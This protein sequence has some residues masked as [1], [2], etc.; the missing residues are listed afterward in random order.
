MIAQLEIYW[1]NLFTYAFWVT[2]AIVC[3]VLW[4]YSDKLYFWFFEEVNKD[5]DE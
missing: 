2:Y 4:K 1:D 5:E 3:Y